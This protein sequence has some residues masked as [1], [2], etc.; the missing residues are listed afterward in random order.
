MN[1]LFLGGGN[2]AY[3]LIGGM[4]DKGIAASEIQVIDPGSEARARLH[5]AYGV[6]SY[7]QAADAPAAPDVL[8]LAVKPQQMREAVAPWQGRLGNALVISIAAGLDLAT[9]ARWLGASAAGAGHAEYA[10]TGRCRDDR[11]LR[12][13]GCG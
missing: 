13:G 1:I 11:L 8:L 3:A 10:G 2:M 7:A 12:H 5:Q 4:L 9:L 6:V